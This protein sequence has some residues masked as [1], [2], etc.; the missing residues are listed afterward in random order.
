MNRF[1][2]NFLEIRKN[3]N[4]I[5][6]E[7]IFRKFF[8]AF[9]KFRKYCG[10][11]IDAL[12]ITILQSAKTWCDGLAICNSDNPCVVFSSVANYAQE[13]AICARFQ[14]LTVFFVLLLINN[15]MPVKTFTTSK[16]HSCLSYHP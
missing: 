1:Q 4:A 6:V 11:D 7:K 12:A 2:E 10:G 16:N 3:A 13:L 5:R 15:R 8:H 9:F 14:F